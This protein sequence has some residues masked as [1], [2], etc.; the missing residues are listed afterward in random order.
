MPASPERGPG[1]H[2]KHGAL[3]HPLHDVFLEHGRGARAIAAAAALECWPARLLIDREIGVRRVAG[4][5]LEG[6]RGQPR[7]D[8]LNESLGRGRQPGLGAELA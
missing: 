8:R 6:L 5:H 7:A 1:E 4:V 2:L 3:R